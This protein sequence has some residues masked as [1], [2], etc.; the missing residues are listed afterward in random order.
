[1]TGPAAD[2]DWEG[3]CDVVKNY[4]AQLED[5]AMPWDVPPPE[6]A[7]ILD[8]FARAQCAAAQHEPV[9]WAFRDG[10]YRALAAAHAGRSVVVLALCG[11]CRTWGEEAAPV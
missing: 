7:G 3:F 2:R 4:A 9:Q 11:K 5:V 1:M 10:Y 8:R 6:P